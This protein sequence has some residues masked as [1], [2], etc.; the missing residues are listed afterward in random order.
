M[1]INGD[2]AIGDAYEYKPLEPL[3]FSKGL[4]ALQRA[5]ELN[6]A[7]KKEKAAA[8]LARE[9]MLYDQKKESDRLLAKNLADAQ[10]QLQVDVGG[11][12]PYLIPK[13]QAEM[14][15][16]GNTVSTILNRG[17]N[18]SDWNDPEVA[19]YNQ[20]VLAFKN[21][22]G[23]NV[24]YYGSVIE[25]TK[26]GKELLQNGEEL[27]GYDPENDNLAYIDYVNKNGLYGDPNS[28][29]VPKGFTKKPA[30]YTAADLAKLHKEEA[31]LVTNKSIDDKG[32]NLGN[33]RTEYTNRE[34]TTADV[35]N[36]RSTVM[37][38]QQKLNDGEELNKEEKKR[39]ISEQRLAAAK[40][41]VDESGNITDEYWSDLAKQYSKIETSE[42]TEYHTP[43]TPPKTSD[44]DNTT[45]F[46]FKNLGDGRYE[47]GN[48][49]N[50]FAIKEGSVPLNTDML[51]EKEGSNFF[52]AANNLLKVPVIPSA[53]VVDLGYNFDPNEVDISHIVAIDEDGNQ[54]PVTTQPD[55]TAA[56]RAIVR[57]L[58]K[59]TNGQYGVSV[60]NNNGKQDLPDQDIVD[61]EASYFV[62]D[63]TG[64]RYIMP[65][66][67]ATPTL[68]TYT[69][70]PKKDVD[71]MF[72]GQQVQ[73]PVVK[74]RTTPKAETTTEKPLAGFNYSW[75][76]PKKK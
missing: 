31:K 55:F 16:L 48:T 69:R 50:I 15:R 73:T 53:G 24:S 4:S 67:K 72:G 7:R 42:S 41:F 33:F 59:R 12:H 38:L 66:I 13:I 26:K 44:S 43:Y 5:N 65:A 18:I 20:D 32:R 35:N 62:K 64:N 8:D 37:G 58:P 2:F 56:Q 52:G 17:G 70:I 68:K 54:I 60:L 9:K 1:A 28:P 36:S 22:V 3:D 47:V 34:V 19:K 71:A 25:S 61:Y 76:I 51:T 49:K 10:Q 45:N 75:E 63:K 11:V 57:Y 39:L 46:N 14:M 21:A 27:E 23:R 6:E 29:F 30:L 74:E 40:G